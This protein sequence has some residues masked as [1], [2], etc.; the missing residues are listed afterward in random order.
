MIILPDRNIPRSRILMPMRRLSWMQPSHAQPKTTEGDPPCLNGWW[1]KAVLAD[2]HVRWQGFF[3]DR[4]DADAFFFAAIMGSLNHEPAL[5]DLPRPCYCPDHGEGAT[6]L[7]A[8][9][10]ILTSGTT[11]TVPSDYNSLTT[12]NGI[13]GGAHGLAGGTTDGGGSGGGGASAA[14]PALALTASQTTYIKIGSAGA[15]GGDTWFNRL[16]NIAPTDPA[17][18]ILAKGASTYTGGQASAC[19]GT[20]KYNGGNGRATSSRDSGCGGGGAGGTTAAGGTGSASHSNR[21]GTG[22][23]GGAASGGAGGN[24]GSGTIGGAN[25]AAGT[26]W[27]GTTGAGGG[28]EGVALGDATHKKGGDGGNYGAGGGGGSTTYTTPGNGK[29]GVLYFEYL[30]GLTSITTMRNLAMMGM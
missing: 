13:G 30:P 10:S 14:V 11:Y 19:I 26:T 4:E 20:T 5:W 8:A 29:Q 27:N 12:L 28:G 23:D 3:D 2:G 22:G 16:S 15:S 25:G 24:S 1:I 9:F 17:D 18:G 7:I 6:F 21:G